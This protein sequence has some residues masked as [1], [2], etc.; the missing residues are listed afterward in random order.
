MSGENEVSQTRKHIQSVQTFFSNFYVFSF[1]WAFYFILYHMTMFLVVTI[2]MSKDHKNTRTHT[3]GHT[4]THA[5]IK[6]KVQKLHDYRCRDRYSQKNKWWLVIK[7]TCN[8]Q[9]TQNL[10][11]SWVSGTVEDNSSTQLVCLIKSGFCITFI[12]HSSHLSSLNC[13]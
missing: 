4:R 5:R 8:F 2:T 13:C 1:F 7:Y 10:I 12:Q 3:H 6:Y 9:S 11:S